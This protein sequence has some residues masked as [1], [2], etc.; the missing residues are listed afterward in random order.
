M[1]ETMGR[2]RDKLAIGLHDLSTVEPP[3]NYKAVEPEKASFKPLEYDRNMQLGDILDEHEKGQEYAWILEDEDR[4][5]II[6]DQ[7]GRVLSF[8]PIIN[9][10]LT[11]VYSGT[12]DIFIDVTGKDRDKVMK[13]LNI[14]V[15]ALAERGGDIESV[16]IDGEEMP[17]L[18]PEEMKLDPGYFREVSGLELSKSEIMERL[19]MMKYD[20]TAGEEIKVETPCYRNDV[21]HQ[22]DLIEDVIIAHRYTNIDPELPEVDQI[23]NQREIE[24]TSQ[25]VRDIMSGT[26]AMEAMTYVHSSEEDLTDKMGYERDSYVKVENPMSEEYS[27][28]R[29]LMLPSL[30]DVLEN[31]KHRAYPQK[32]FE[33]GNVVV[34]NDSGS[35]AS[36]RKKAAF[37]QV[38]DN[39]DFNDAKKSIQVLERDLGIDLEVKEEN[40]PYFREDRSAVLELNGQRAGNVGEFS[41]EVLGKWSL[42]KPVAG[43]EIDLELIQEDLKK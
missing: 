25:V 19:K 33:T 32:F 21:M 23:G 35:G 27:A 12:E 17:D 38:G 34:I 28:V 20:A 18:S 7:E 39:T 36:N 24:D 26:G 37:V 15:T 5:P 13:A 22:Y 10:Q 41:T 16:E 42:E 11:E 30:L 40:I 3:F 1:H 8:P 43:F 31:N 4:Y 6:E 2:R 14:M 9:N 29:D